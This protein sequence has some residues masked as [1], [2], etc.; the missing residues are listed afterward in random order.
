MLVS[1]ILDVVDE[2]TNVYVQDVCT[3]KLI[4]HYDGRNGIDTE[5]LVYPVEHIYTNNSGSIVLEVMYE[6][7]NYEDRR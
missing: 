4:S 6:F 2:N 7:V 3:K 5:L 1:N